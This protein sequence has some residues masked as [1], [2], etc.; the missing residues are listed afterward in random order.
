MSNFV[1]QESDIV[2]QAIDETS[3]TQKH[4]L[5]KNIRALDVAATDYGSGEFVYLKGLAS[6][7]V[8]EC[9]MYSEDGHATKLAVANDAGSIAFAMSACVTGEFGWYQV[10]GKAVGLALASF[11][12]NAACYLTATAGSIDDEVVA[13]D[14][15]HG[16]ISASA[17][18]TPSTG[19][20]ELEINYP[21]TDNVAD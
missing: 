2:E 3:T 9:V 11:G 14:R 7:A 1:S 17:V 15:L 13:G 5:G 16:C 10:K 21:R 19:L 4:P 12:D 8:G 18:D 6:T 20:A